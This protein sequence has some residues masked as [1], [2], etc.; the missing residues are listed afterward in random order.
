VALVDPAAQLE[1][2]GRVE[3]AGTQQL[4]A[5]GVLRAPPGPLAQRESRP[6]DG[7]SSQRVPV[8]PK[9]GAGETHDEVPRLDPGREQRVPVDDADREPDQIRT[10]PVP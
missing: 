8:A 1:H 3:N 5:E 7:L 2:R 4:R 6:V 9:P 10:R